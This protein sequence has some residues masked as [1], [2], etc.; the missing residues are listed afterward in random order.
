MT[1]ALRI[2]VF[3]VV[4]CKV[5]AIISRSLGPD[6]SNAFVSVTLLER[7]SEWIVNHVIYRKCRGLRLPPTAKEEAPICSSSGE[8]L[9]SPMQVDDDDEKALQENFEALKVRAP[10]QHQDAATVANAR[11][12]AEA[13][14]KATPFKKIM[15]ANFWSADELA[16]MND[17]P[18][19]VDIVDEAPDIHIGPTIPAMS[20]LD[21]EGL[22]TSLLVQPIQPSLTVVPISPTLLGGERSSTPLSR[23]RN[24]KIAEARNAALPAFPHALG[25]E[26]KRPR[27]VDDANALHI[28]KKS[29]IEGGFSRCDQPC[30]H[31][32]AC[33]ELGIGRCP[34][35]HGSGD[36]ASSSSQDAPEHFTK[37]TTKQ[38]LTRPTA[39][40]SPR[41]SKR[42]TL[43][44]NYCK[45][46]YHAEEECRQKQ[47][48]LARPQTIP[49]AQPNMQ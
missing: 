49:S 16:S 30:R 46:Q 26:R 22:P 44:C 25:K 21:T 5:L 23:N 45:R 3:V 40:P 4:G 19:D 43:V 31:G 8:G 41:P 37:T 12:R 9:S 38:Q 28:H 20:P 11:N 27:G 29:K 36:Q 7:S 35:I 48:D 10:A 6:L 33:T 47:R 1:R 13:I 15:A 24:H 39:F 18:D 42:S 32:A 34:F 17:N 14:L 2:D